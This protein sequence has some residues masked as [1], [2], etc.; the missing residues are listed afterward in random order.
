MAKDFF[1]QS[2]YPEQFLPIVGFYD[3]RC[4]NDAWGGER[5]PNPSP[6]KMVP[7]NLKIQFVILVYPK[8]VYITFNKVPLIGCYFVIDTSDSGKDLLE[9]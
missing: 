5:I 6:G 4:L 1:L 9:S 3:N 8:T 7:K 2:Y